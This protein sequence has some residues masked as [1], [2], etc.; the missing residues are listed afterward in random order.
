MKFRD[1]SGKSS[2]SAVEMVDPANWDDLEE[3]VTQMS[4]D[5]SQKKVVRTQRLR[6]GC[7]LKKIAQTLEV[8]S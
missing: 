6:I 3:A 7:L 1:V 5:K 4:V 8:R 2:A